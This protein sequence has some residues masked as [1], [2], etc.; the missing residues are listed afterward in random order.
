MKNIIKILLT[1]FIVLTLS[2]GMVKA[3]E[4][5][6]LY[7]LYHQEIV[8]RMDGHQVWSCLYLKKWIENNEYKEDR[9]EAQFPLILS[10]PAILPI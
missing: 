5:D 1:S 7:H 8:T 2:N 9:V 3:N 4:Y 6:G 10:C